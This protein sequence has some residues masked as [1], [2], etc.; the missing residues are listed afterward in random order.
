MGEQG[1]FTAFALRFIKGLQIIRSNQKA[2]TYYPRCNGQAESTNKVLKG[3][4]TKMAQT[5]KGSWDMHLHSAF[6]AYR[7]AFKVTTRQTPF[8]LAFGQEAVVPFEFSVC[9]H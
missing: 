3:I 2:T 6:W 4:L 5:M 9:Q 8:M 1:L 7:T